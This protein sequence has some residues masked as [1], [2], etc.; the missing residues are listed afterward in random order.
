M[1]RSEPNPGMAGLPKVALA[2][3]AILTFALALPGVANAQSPRQAAS[4]LFDSQVP[5]SSTGLTQAIDYF[6][7]DDPEAKPPAVATIVISLAKG[8]RIDTAV[9]P[10][11]EAPDPALIAQGAAAC[12]EGSI[13]GGGE[14]DLDTGIPGPSRIVRNQVELINNAD[15]LIFL[16][17][18]E[19]GGARTVTRATVGERTVTTETPPIP[20]GPPDGFTAIK[21]VR[22]QMEA[23][24]AGDGNYLT[25]PPSCPAE[26]E[27]TATGEFTYRDGV[28]QLTSSASPCIELP[29]SC[30]AT[31][32]APV[33]GTGGGETL[34]GGP[35]SDLLLALGGRD[36]VSGRGGDD[37]LYGAQGKDTL[38][39]NAGDD[40]VEGAEGRDL[41]E[42]GKG[43]DLLEGGKGFDRIRG[44]GGNDTVRGED[45]DDTLNGGVGRDRL[46][47]GSGRDRLRAGDGAD[48]LNG[49]AGDDVLRGGGGRNLIE[50]GG[51][52]DKVIV[53]ADSPDRIDRSCERV[54]RR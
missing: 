46:T 16:L 45:G 22:L 1:R 3:I 39:G 5:G 31:N 52:R 13:V 10:Q 24:S 25:T 30:R 48:T 40:L 42:G 4:A 15:E 51:G 17:T 23:F 35:G 53:V 2:T 33:V 41:L 20:G 27:W 32:P 8:S 11:C 9:P 38:R 36:L 7:P 6:N 37:C 12:P 34:L 14:I 18:E 28:T 21:R 26:G 49:G 29:R 50:C 43:A 54:I 44:A 47:G 19:E